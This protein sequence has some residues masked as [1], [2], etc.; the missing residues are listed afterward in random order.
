LR[1]KENQLSRYV[2]VI[3][4]L[5]TLLVSA[6]GSSGSNLPQSAKDLPPGD[7]NRG[8]QLF[9][10]S[11]DGAPPCST[12]HSVDGSTLVGPSFKGFGAVA[13]TRI[14]GMSAIDYV[15]QSITQ[16]STYIVNGYSNI[17]Y[18]QYAQHLT[19]Q[20]IADLAAYVLSR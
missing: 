9:T 14:S 13:G 8:A 3:A 5:L 20:Q 16:P 2:V 4:V 15:Y 18:N 7:A 11:I 17:M 1:R 19:A 6:C 12:C 10:Q